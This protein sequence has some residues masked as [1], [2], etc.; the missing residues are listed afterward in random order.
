MGDFGRRKE[1]ALGFDMPLKLQPR[2]HEEDRARIV[3]S[4]RL[5]LAMSE[6]PPTSTPPPGAEELSQAGIGEGGLVADAPAADH[7]PV[8]RSATRG[9]RFK[10]AATNVWV[11]GGTFIVAII[12]L[13]AAGTQAGIAIGAGAAAAVLL[14]ALIIVF[15]VASNQAANDFYEA[16]AKSR[17]LSRVGG[18]GSL[19]GV[20]PLLR[21]GDRRYTEEIFNGLLPGGLSGA[22]ALYT[23]EDT[24]TDSKG[25]RQTTYYHYTVAV[26][27]LPE[28]APFLSELALQRRAGFRF[29]DK[30]EDVFRTRQRVEVESTVADKKFEIFTGKSDDL[31]R[32]RQVLS[33]VFVAWLAEDAHE[34]LAF[35][36]VAGAFVANS[37]GHLKTA[38]EL[39]AFCEASA[40]IARRLDEEACE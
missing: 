3:R 24:S 9:K 4:D 8:H 21:K 5:P 27:Q 22:L 37:K 23:Y 20:T 33:P 14:I 28:T 38:Q 1:A 30:A 2:L 11:L 31:S 7:L 40:L 39:D 36:L 12:A 6:V 16:Y 19:P 34:N 35:E 32:A 17:G 15:V 26:S 10:A 18:K 25:N 29:M 13:I